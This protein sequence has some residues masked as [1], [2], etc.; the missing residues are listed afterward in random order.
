MEN[1]ERLKNAKNEK[2]WEKL[3]NTRNEKYYKT[4]WILLMKNTEN[5]ALKYTSDHSLWLL[6]QNWLVRHRFD[7]LLE[8]WYDPI[9]YLQIVAVQAN[10]VWLARKVRL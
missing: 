2:Y 10:F 4:E 9:F 1:A 6:I 5:N 3:K 7:F 8:T